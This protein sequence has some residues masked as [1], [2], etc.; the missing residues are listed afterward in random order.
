MQIQA[1]AIAA[2]TA[3]LAMPSLH[4]DTAPVPLKQ[5]ERIVFF[6]DS[7]TAAAVNPGGYIALIQQSLTAEKPDLKIE[8]IGAGVSGNKVP[9]LQARLEKAVIEKNPSIVFIYIGI[10]DVWHWNKN[11]EGELT[12]GTPKAVFESGLK[13]IIAKINAAGAR[14]ILCTAS[15]IG[16]KHDGSNPTDEML[17]EYCAISR[18]VAKKTK[19]QMVDLR[20]AFLNHLRANNPDN[21][22]RGILTG[23]GVHLNAAGNKLVAEKMCAALG[24]KLVEAPATP[25]APAAPAAK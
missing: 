13:D 19:S 21:L 20:K 11:K 16:E 3:V 2:F 4:A 6:G 18:K 10:N 7:I 24:I 9:D 12:G 8:T 25:A 14:V 23:D 22:P 5:G 1:L 15:V 17:D